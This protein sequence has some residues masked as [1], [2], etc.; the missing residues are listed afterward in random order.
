MPE[1][2]HV[3]LT[4]NES[5]EKS[6]QF[7]KGGLSFRMRDHRPNLEI[8]Q[9][10]FTDHRIRDDQD[11]RIHRVYVHMNPV[12]RGLCARPEEYPYSSAYAGF[13]TDDLPQRLKPQV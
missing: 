4:P 9:K 1:H 5:L 7:I 13:E 12:R 6:L 11:Y 3:I 8:W 10:G 2:F